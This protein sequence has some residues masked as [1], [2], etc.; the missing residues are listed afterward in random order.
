MNLSNHPRK[1]VYKKVYP[2]LTIHKEKTKFIRH[3]WYNRCDFV[4]RVSNRNSVARNGCIRSRHFIARNCAIITNKE[5]IKYSRNCAEL[6]ATELLFHLK[7][8]NFNCDL[9]IYAADTR[10]K[11]IE[12]QVARNCAEL[13]QIAWN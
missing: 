8:N 12:S 5:A 4:A 10:I 3:Y 7:I 2:L 11:I 6:R 13:R 1:F 9:Q